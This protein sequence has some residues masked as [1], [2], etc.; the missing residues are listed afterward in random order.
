MMLWVFRVLGPSGV[1]RTKASMVADRVGHGGPG[2]L[3][4][5][6]ACVNINAVNRRKACG[7]VGSF[8]NCYRPPCHIRLTGLRKRETT[9]LAR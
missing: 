7:K 6:M 2:G 1:A 5:S 8:V 3:Y 9:L 4:L